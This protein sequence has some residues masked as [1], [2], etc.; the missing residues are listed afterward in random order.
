MDLVDAEPPRHRLGRDGVVAGRHDDLQAARRA[1][2]GCACGRVRL[3]R[4]GDAPAA[5]PA[6]PRRR[7]TSPFGPPLPQRVGASLEAVRIDTAP[8]AISAA[9]P[10]A[11]PAAGDDCRARPC[12]SPP[13]TPLAAVDRQR[14]AL[15]RPATIAS[16]S[17]CSEPLS[18][19]AA[20]ASRLPRRDRRS[21]DDRQSAPAALRSACRSCRRSACRPRQSAPAPR[22]PGPARRPARR[23][24]SPS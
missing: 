19:A 8:I 1:G 13:R 14:R 6:C 18:S 23:G 22:H 2:P 10:S 5:R 11:T 9:L 4:I 15:R 20:S 24:R 17:G 21:R 16:A 7:R 3:D 12:R